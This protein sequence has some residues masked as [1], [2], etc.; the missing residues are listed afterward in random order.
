[1]ITTKQ[2]VPFQKK[3]SA[4]ASQVES[5]EIV[6][7]TSMQSGVVILSNMNKYMDSVKEQKEKLTK[8]I[9]ESLKNIRAMFKPL[10][11]TYETAIEALR[12]KMTKFQ[13]ESVAKARIEEQKIADRVG[14]GTGHLKIETAIKQIEKVETP[15]KEISTTSGLVQ[16]VETK[17]FEVTNLAAVPVD[18]ILPNEVAIRNAM[19]LGKEIPG[20]RYYTEMVPRNFR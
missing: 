20:V 3:V 18:Y 2:L 7:A 13:T 4:L 10:E 5:L 8:P 6:D 1:M 11:T 16:F 15:E 14:S 12:G 9:N 17:K 19:K